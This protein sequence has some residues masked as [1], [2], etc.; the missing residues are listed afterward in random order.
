ML[1]LIMLFSC[2]VLFDSANPWTATHQA[3]LTTP[4]PGVCSNSYPLSWWYHPTILSCVIPFSCC[5]QSLPVSGSFPVSGLFPSGGQ[6]VG[7]LALAS[8]LPM[9]LRDDFLKHWLVWSPCNPG[10]SQNS[11]PKPQFKGISFSDLSLLYGLS[12]TSIHDN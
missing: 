3:S 6:S 4:S 8:V 10:D 1:C 11:S 9:K 2:S 5:L 7:A 12:L